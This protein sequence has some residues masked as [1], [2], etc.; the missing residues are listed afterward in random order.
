MIKRFFDI[1]LEANTSSNKDIYLEQ[2]EKGES[3]KNAAYFLLDILT[4]GMSATLDSE[5]IDKYVNKFIKQ[6]EDSFKK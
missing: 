4:T 2:R 1:L 5:K 6:F 3:P